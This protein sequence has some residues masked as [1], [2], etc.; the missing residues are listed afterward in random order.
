MC[1]T[2]LETLR[3]LK[4]VCDER[5][6]F[7]Q[8]PTVFSCLV[9]RPDHQF[10]VRMTV[11]LEDS[12]RAL[13]NLEFFLPW[14]MHARKPKVPQ[15]YFIRGCILKSALQPLHFISRHNARHPLDESPSM[16]SKRLC[17]PPSVSDIGQMVK[18]PPKQAFALPVSATLWQS[19]CLRYQ[20]VR[21]SRHPSEIWYSS[22]HW[23]AP[24]TCKEL[25]SIVYD[26]AQGD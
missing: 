26:I 20:P 14:L 13:Y 16:H 19:C 12:S 9:R 10:Q 23:H 5:A 18:A 4:N 24:T 11:A 22:H 6:S 7:V 2:S 8:T 15:V 21:V 1:E 17:W 3:A 25:R